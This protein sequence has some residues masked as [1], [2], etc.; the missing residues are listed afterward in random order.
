MKKNNE[1]KKTNN[2]STLFNDD[3]EKKN[4]SS[5]SF[6]SETDK[7]EKDENLNIDSSTKVSEPYIESGFNSNTLTKESV[8]IKEKTKNE[9][10]NQR[11]NKKRKINQ[12]TKQKDN[13]EKY[14]KC[15]FL[16][17]SMG[18]YSFL[19]TKSN[20]KDPELINHIYTALLSASEQRLYNKELKYLYDYYSEQF[21]MLKKVDS[22]EVNEIGFA[23]F[24][25]LI[26]NEYKNFGLNSVHNRTVEYI[27][28]SVEVVYDIRNGKKPSR[29]I[30]EFIMYFNSELNTFNG[31][32]EFINSQNP[33]DPFLNFNNI[34]KK[35]SSLLVDNSAINNSIHYWKEILLQLCYV[36]ERSTKDPKD[37]V[38]SFIEKD[39]VGKS[40]LSI[41]ITAL[42]IIHL[43][44][45]RPY[46][47]TLPLSFLDN[48]MMNIIS[49]SVEIFIDPKPIIEYAQKDKNL[50]VKYFWTYV[51][52]KPYSIFEKPEVKEVKK[53]QKKLI[54]VEEE[55]KVEEKSFGDFIK[56]YG[57]AKPTGFI[58]MKTNL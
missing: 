13:Y 22:S 34:S 31:L 25:S 26:S 20:I 6:N 16:A 30:I 56:I 4:E 8:E 9:L 57:E 7:K 2:S 29:A 28:K 51:W 54:E 10:K 49:P 40:E 45:G 39:I 58:R 14:L 47:K 37:V 23:L 50:L 53:F 42:I 24:I 55:V 43:F 15:R 44:Y 12:E 11:D 33:D 48:K 32:K 46:E 35:I 17:S 18:F 27:N 21:K 5:Q 3:A 19:I 1:K 38:Y 36:L 52:G 41:I